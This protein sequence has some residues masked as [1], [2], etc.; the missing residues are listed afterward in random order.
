MAESSEYHKLK[1]TEFKAKAEAF[2]KE[3]NA[4]YMSHTLNK[5]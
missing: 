3:F 5:A 2:G 1:D 4:I